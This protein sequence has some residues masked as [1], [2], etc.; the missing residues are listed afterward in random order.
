[1][2]LEEPLLK[3]SLYVLQKLKRPTPYI[4]LLIQ[5]HPPDFYPKEILYEHQEA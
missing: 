5:Q 2:Y 1:M 3:R 4:I